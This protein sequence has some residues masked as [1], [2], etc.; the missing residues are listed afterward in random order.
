MQGSCGAEMDI[1]IIGAGRVGTALAAG[2]LRSGHRVLIGSRDS[3][4]SVPGATTMSPTDAAEAALVIVLS[5]P[6]AA[7][8]E[9]TAAL[10]PLAG[11]IIIDCMNPISRTDRGPGL[12]LGHTT[13]GGETVQGWLPQARVVKTLN[14]VGAEVI[15]DTSGFAHPPAMFMAGDD[16]A[17][18]VT[19]AALL[20]DLGFDP[21]DAGDIT[22]ARILEPW[23][24]VWINQALMR[25]KGRDWA[26]AALPRRT[27]LTD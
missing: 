7:A 11:K 15:A 22:K 24:L 23:A 13:S 25:G 2:W 9:V 14:Q 4:T 27:G 16:D 5:L 12:V 3:G 8:E 6:W 10:G 1:A 17:A 20:S 21:F 19:V 26:F 18:K